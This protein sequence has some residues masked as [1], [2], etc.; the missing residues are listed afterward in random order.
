[1]WRR[2]PSRRARTDAGNSRLVRGIAAAREGRGG[3]I[4]VSG[5]AGI[6]KSR[7]LDEAVADTPGMVR[8]RCLTEDGTPPLWPWLRILR[9]I[10]A[11]LLP[12]G[13]A[14]TGAMD[15]KE[16]A[17][18]RFRRGTRRP[19]QVQERD[20]PMPQAIHPPRA[21]EDSDQPENPDHTGKRS[22]E[23]RLTAIGA[24]DTVGVVHAPTLR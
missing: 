9:Q 8:G 11:D 14:G 13:V 18:E 2:A 1:M 17:G 16:A 19:S 22:Y 23:S 10:P 4:V 12:A 7:L 20:P 3:N 24:S 5:P 21:L 6:G 15:A